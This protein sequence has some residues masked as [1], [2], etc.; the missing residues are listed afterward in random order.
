MIKGWCVPYE[1]N[2]PYLEASLCFIEKYLTNLISAPS[3]GGQQTNQIIQIHV[4]RI[5]VCEVQYGG[6][7]TDD[8]D[9]EM[10][11]AYNEDYLKDGI[12]QPDHCYAE[13]K[14]EVEGG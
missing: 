5:M 4:I 10:F 9:R 8:L 6:R 14:I 13:I 2:I 11:N 7:I 3:Q 1:F 12:L